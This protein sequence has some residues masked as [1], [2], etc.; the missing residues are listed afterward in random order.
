M[1]CDISPI[2]A[3]QVCIHFPCNPFL[4][5]FHALLSVIKKLVQWLKIK[6]DNC[7]ELDIKNT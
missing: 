6:Q 1:G 3:P 7:D 5:H 4:H 2:P